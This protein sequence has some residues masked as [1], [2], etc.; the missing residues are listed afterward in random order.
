MKDGYFF[1]RKMDASTQIGLRDFLDRKLFNLN[2]ST[3]CRAEDIGY[4]DHCFRELVTQ[5]AATSKDNSVLIIP[6]NNAQF[7]IGMNLYCS[8]KRQSMEKQVLFLSYDYTVHAKLVER[9]ILSYY[10]PINIWGAPEYQPWHQG[11]FSKMMRQKPILWRMLMDIGVNFWQL[12]ADTVVI[13][14]I[15]NVLE[16]DVDVH[17]AIDEKEYLDLV[18]ALKPVPNVSTGIMH[19]RNTPGTRV[20]INMIQ[21]ILNDISWMEEQEAFNQLV[22]TEI[23]SGSPR[24]T[25]SNL[26]V[27]EKWKEYYKPLDNASPKEEIKPRLAFLN[28]LQFVSGHFFLSRS[29]AMLREVYRKVKVVHANSREDKE[30]EFKRRGLWLLTLRGGIK[31]CPH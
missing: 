12:D 31:T 19:F 25:L 23:S 26:K 20:L 2:D 14:P 27:P 30:S 5:A 22:F 18:L 4:R 9:R 29:D 17:I 16:L 8:I 6:L 3:P 11:S 28:Q 10:N 1:V 21:S 13:H 15:G 24:L 7:D